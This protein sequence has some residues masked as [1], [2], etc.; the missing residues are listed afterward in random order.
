MLK[1][2][3][4]ESNLKDTSWIESKIHSVER[5][6]YSENMLFENREIYELDRLEYGDLES[7]LE[8]KLYNKKELALYFRYSKINNFNLMKLLWNWADIVYK[9][10]H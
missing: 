1:E 2:G 7:Q 9:I 3:L 6:T 10:I 5:L 8:K 4:K